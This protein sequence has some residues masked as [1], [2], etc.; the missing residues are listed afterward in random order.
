MNDSGGGPLLHRQGEEYLFKEGC[1]IREISNSVHD[2]ALSI[3]QARVDPGVTTRWHC[4]QGVVERYQI[5]GGI[6]MVEIGSAAPLVVVTGDVVLIPAGVR[7]RIT[8]H[9]HHALLFLALCTPRFLPHLYV[10][11]EDESING[12]Q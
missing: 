1:Y 11:L 10:D 6:G 12:V 7:Q 4:L 9:G 3:A 8:N 2:P 5:L